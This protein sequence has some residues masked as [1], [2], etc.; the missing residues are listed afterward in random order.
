VPAPADGFPE[1]RRLTGEPTGEAALRM[2]Y[3]KLRRSRLILGAF[4]LF[5]VLITA[6]PGIDLSISRFFFH[7]GSFPLD[8][9]QRLVHVGLNYF[10]WISLTTVIAI[11]L[12]NR[13][14]KRSLCAIDGKRVLYLLFVLIVGAGLIVNAGLKDNFGRA[15][16]RDVVE[17]SGTKQ[18]TPAFVISGEC[19]SNCSFSSGDAAGGFFSLALAL[20]LTRRRAIFAAA[21]GVGILVSFARIASGAHFFSDTVVSFFIMLILADVAYFY[22]VLTDADRAELDLV[23]TVLKPA[24]EVVPNEIP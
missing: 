16:P 19:R 23:G 4:L 15:R 6:L 8:P 5:S 13:L 18:F 10:L 24:A 22:M 11:Y 3:L 12:H 20:A 1:A 17:F 21:A 14:L 7:G 9:W 2:H